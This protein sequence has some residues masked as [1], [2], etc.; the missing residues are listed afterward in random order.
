MGDWRIIEDTLVIK[1]SDASIYLPPAMEIFQAEYRG[2][3]IINNQEIIVPSR[4]FP[5]IR[6]SKY[7]LKL[8][9]TLKTSNDQTK[10]LLKVELTGN[11]GETSI[12]IKNPL[13]RTADQ[14]IH[15]NVWYAFEGGALE[16]VKRLLIDANISNEHYITL[17]Q[18]FYLLTHSIDSIPVSIGMDLHSIPDL[19]SYEEIPRNF[20]GI[21]YPYQNIGYRWLCMIYKEGLGCILGDEM[22]LGKTVQMICLIARNVERQIRPALIVAPATLLENW[23]RE[24]EK[25]APSITTYVHIGN[26]RTGFPSDL[27]TYDVII[28]SFSTLIRDTPLFRMVSWDIIVADEAQAIKNPEAERTKIIKSLPRNVAIAVTGTPV[29]NGLTDLWSIMDFIIPDLLGERANFEK[30]YKNNIEGAT[31]LEPLVTPVILRRAISEVAKELPQRIDIPQPIEMTFE[32]AEE[33]E[34]IRQEI[35]A[36]YGE[37]AQLVSLQKL[38]MFCA[39]PSLVGGHVADLYE[40]SPKYQRLIEIVEEIFENREQVLIFTSFTNMID[41]LMADLPKRF[42]D[43][44]ISW[45]D[46][47][48]PINERQPRVDEF[49]NCKKPAVLVL[50]PTAAGTGLNLTAANHVIHYNL[51]WN[52]AVEDQASARAHRI[53]QKKP[54]TV[55]RLYF[56]GSVEEII[57]NKLSFKRDLAQATVKGVTGD[58]KDYSDIFTALQITPVKKTTTQ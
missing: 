40:K 7:P 24:F 10:G 30:R 21:L 37:C 16:D 47:R 31:D 4:A 5:A 49:N 42:S 22:G 44:W 14:I 15:E 58:Q 6:F 39:H 9:I 52:P 26:E 23:R 36:K 28:T 17:H 51:E 34:Q 46:G 25:F 35:L 29:Q 45:I 54:V 41:I 43:I 33:Y 1:S 53:G 55:H 27:E 3:K 11:Y 18:M 8:I 20:K 12:Q 32:M 38:R 2:K 57:N 13:N 50:N 56:I 48:I 19:A